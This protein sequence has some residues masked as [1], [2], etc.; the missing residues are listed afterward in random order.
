MILVFAGMFPNSTRSS[1]VGSGQWMLTPYD[2]DNY[3]IYC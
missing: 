2:R 3:S 1:R